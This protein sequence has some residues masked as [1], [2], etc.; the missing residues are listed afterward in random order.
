MSDI[1]LQDE[2]LLI[3]IVRGRGSGFEEAASEL[4]DRLGGYVVSMVLTTGN[5]Q[6]DD[7]DEV[8]QRVWLRAFKQNA[9]EHFETAEEFRGWL[10]KVAISRT[11]DELRR[12]TRKRDR[13]TSVV[14]D[15][16]EGIQLEDPRSEAL[17]SCMDKLTESRPEYAAVVRAVTSGVTG[18][19]IAGS[20]RIKQNTV[21]SRFNRAK[22]A[23]KDCIERSLAR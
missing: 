17:G 8:V 12:N 11:I 23:L 2:H 5:L 7:L 4:V 3:R 18:E 13:E 10:K 6:N 20:L 19:E 14:G 1:L 22:E 16:S 21:Y 15:F 9:D